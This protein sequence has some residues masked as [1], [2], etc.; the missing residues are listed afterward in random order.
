MSNLNL[1]KYGIADKLPKLTKLQKELSGLEQHKAKAERQVTV[2][3]QQVLHAR[4]KDAVAASLAIRAG[5]EMPEPENEREALS[6]LDAAE[7]TLAATSKAVEA[8]RSEAAQ[9]VSENREEIRSALLASLRDSAARLR[10]HAMAAAS[11]YGVLDDAHYVLKR[12]LATPASLAPVENDEPARST[13]SVIGAVHI[14][15]SDP[16]SGIVLQ[17]LEF[18][19]S[20]EERFRESRESETSADTESGAA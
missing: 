6:A 17:H 2:W 9:F 1:K 20:L 10:E 7:R 16:P 19:A 8:V 5:K 3:Q 12:E 13:Y 4:D 14:Q 15:N 11:I 18:L